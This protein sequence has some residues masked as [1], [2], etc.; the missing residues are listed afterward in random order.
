MIYYYLIFAFALVF[1]LGIKKK[2]VVLNNGVQRFRSKNRT[3]SIYLFFVFAFVSLIIGLRDI[4]VGIDTKNYIYEYYYKV[5]N[6]SIFN[7][8]I[9]IVINIIAKICPTPQIFLF[10]VGAVT[11]MLFA[12]F[13][14]QNSENV[15]LSTIIFLGMFFVQSM[16]LMREW[17]AIAIGINSL[18]FFKKN[19]YFIGSVILLVAILTHVTAI[20]LIFIPLFLFIKNKRKALYLTTFFCLL[21]VIFKNNIFNL[22]VFIFPK[23]Y[24]YIYSGYFVNESAF[25]IKDLI[26]IAIELYFIYFLLYESW[27]LPNEKKQQFYANIAFLLIA[28][29]FSYCG[30]NI[31]IFHRLVYY[32]SVY[33]II[34]LPEVIEKSSLKSIIVPLLIVAMF[35]MLYRSGISDNNGISE[36]L[37]FWQ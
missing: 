21:F 3:E 26:F 32:Y 15:W 1:S 4:S 12:I 22:V 16:N 14:F 8:S 17:L 33:L 11:S 35:I 31:S 36:Y 5:Q 6:G 23:Y 13:I 30:Q 18:M 34:S 19:K 9:E 27:K 20:S 25:N 24:D 37:F 7:N 29:T 28:I 2:Q 10:V